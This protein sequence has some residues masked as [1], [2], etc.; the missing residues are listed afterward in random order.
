MPGLDP[1]GT[2]RLV[3]TPVLIFGHS[4]VWS[5]RAAIAR[6]SPDPRIAP[7]VLLCGTAAI[8]GSLTVAHLKAKRRALNPA[9]LGALRTAT[10]NE[11]RSDIWIASAVQGNYYNQVGM[12]WEGSPFD[13]VLPSE[14]DLPLAPDA[15]IVPHSAIAE[16]LGRRMPDL[17]EY[18]AELARLE[19]AGFMVLGPPP[20]PRDSEHLL[21]LLRSQTPDADE[22]TISAPFVRL[23]LWK[24]QNDIVG[25]LCADHGA[26]YVR[27]D[28]PGTVDHDG[29][30]RPEFVK[31]AVHASVEYSQRLIG[32]MADEVTATESMALAPSS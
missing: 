10:A 32:R 12:F 25:S 31:D 17:G 26:R 6:D 16:M 28:V 30:L 15:E 7:E 5:I 1:P 24:L 23:K 11:D 22:S 29:F 21:K 8:P 20:P 3:A 18:L 9:I 19:F 4:H 27:G 13:F 2:I 14:P